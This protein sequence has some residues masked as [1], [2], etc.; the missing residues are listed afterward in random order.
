[1][2]AVFAVLMVVGAAAPAAGIPPGGGPPPCVSDVQVSLSASNGREE[3]PVRVGQPVTVSWEVVKPPGCPITQILIRGTGFDPAQNVGF[4]GSRS[5]V[6]PGPGVE[7][8]T[9]SMVYVGGSTQVSSSV[10]V[11]PLPSTVAAT[12]DNEG[13]LNL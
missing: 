5:V 1:M 7:Q 6:I 13:S 2:A 10:T 3:W 9:L 11:L 8:W 4:N 12:L